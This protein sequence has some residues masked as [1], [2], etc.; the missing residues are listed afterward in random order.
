MEFSNPSKKIFD[1]HDV[2]Y[3][4]QSLAYDNLQE[5][6]KAIV[7]MVKGQ[8]LPK[9]VLNPHLVSTKA[10]SNSKSNLPPT[11][12]QA[13]SSKDKDRSNAVLDLGCKNGSIMVEILDQL[14]QFIT[15]TPPIEGPR[16]F[17]NYAFK[18]WYAKVEQHSDR[19]LERLQ[20]KTVDKLGYIK[21]LKC[22]F[23]NSFG[24]HVRLDYGTGHELSFVAVLGSLLKFKLLKDILGT[25]LLVIFAKYYDIVRRLILSYSLEPAGSHGVWGL[26]DHFHFIYILGAAQFNDSVSKMVPPVGQCLQDTVLQDYMNTNLYLNA[27]GFIR[28][29]KSGP[30]NEHSPIL[31]DIHNSVHLWKKVLSG[32]LKMYDVEVLGKFPVVQHFW[33]G[34]VLYPWKDRHEND[35]P[36]NPLHKRSAEA[37]EKPQEAI[38]EPGFLNG[39]G[40]RTT[41]N[42]ISMTGAPWL[43]NNQVNDPTSQIRKLNALTRNG[44]TSAPPPTKFPTPRRQ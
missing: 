19:F 24:S 38:E 25:E 16:R 22:Y 15:D 4:K 7:M 13:E 37:D 29:I 17:G 30:F 26:D 35:L 21:E 32:L 6:I 31:F 3:F 28:K 2:G 12:Q 41:T 11:F 43:R 8:D 33:F 9:N 23:L 39:S 1:G 42:N 18:D 34:N 36:L 5:V 20:I 14:D 40:V 27:I 44:P 10:S